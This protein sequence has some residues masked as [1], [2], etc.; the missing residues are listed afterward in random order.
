MTPVDRPIIVWG[1]F[2]MLFA[3]LHPIFLIGVVI[4]TLDVIARWN[5]YLSIRGYRYQ[6]GYQP[7]ISYHM[8]GSWCSRGVAEF[9]WPH[10]ASSLYKSMGYRWYHILP[11]GF[12][13]V[14]L[15]LAFWRHV[16][17]LK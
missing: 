1:V 16:V 7:G 13:R 8:R 10:G 5:D 14:F 4:M 12:P 2:V 17:G 9:V 6:P 11:D 3:W 15:S